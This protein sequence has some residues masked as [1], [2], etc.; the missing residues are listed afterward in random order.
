[1][2][3]TNINNVDYYE[4][5]TYG[6]TEMDEDPFSMYNET[7]DFI[8]D[9]ELVPFNETH[10]CIR[11]VANSQVE[12]CFWIFIELKYFMR[13]LY[14]PQPVYTTYQYFVVYFSLIYLFKQF[15]SY[16]LLNFIDY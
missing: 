9:A 3:Y 11:L 7:D 12:I 13:L 14:L 4:N 8:Y 5:L 16:R 15:I 1:M 2:S 10:D 6:S